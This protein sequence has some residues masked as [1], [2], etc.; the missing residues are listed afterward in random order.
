MGQAPPLPLAVSSG[1]P[2]NRTVRRCDLSSFVEI[3]P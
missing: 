3:T 1:F 2:Y